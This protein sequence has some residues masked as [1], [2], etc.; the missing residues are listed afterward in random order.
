MF[1]A[2]GAILAAAD[3]QGWRFVAPMFDRE[4]LIAGTRS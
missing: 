1:V 3:I 4:K 2:A